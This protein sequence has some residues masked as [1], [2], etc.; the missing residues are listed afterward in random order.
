M[1]LMLM[2]STEL[3]RDKHKQLNTQ[4]FF[5]NTQKQD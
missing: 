5:K 4:I 1:V 2:S 3:T